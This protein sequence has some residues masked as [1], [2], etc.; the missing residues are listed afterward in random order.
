MDVK[1]QGTLVSL[2]S[3][4][5]TSALRRPVLIDGIGVVD[6]LLDTGAAVNVINASLI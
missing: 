3:G 4:A 6:A 2:S 5:L 1:R